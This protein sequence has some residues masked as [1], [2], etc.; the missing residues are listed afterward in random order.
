VFLDLFV[1]HTS[2]C[3][4]ILSWRTVVKDIIVSQHWLP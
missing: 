2:T 3:F 1:K 4:S